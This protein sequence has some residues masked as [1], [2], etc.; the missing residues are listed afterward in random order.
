MSALPSTFHN[1]SGTCAMT[2]PAL[3]GRKPVLALLIRLFWA[4]VLV[5]PGFGASA[6]VVFTNLYSFTG[7]NDGANP[8]AGPV[9]GR[10][11]NLYG[12]TSSGGTN[13]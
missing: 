12:T 4:S 8:Y 5:L 9:Q 10:D 7:I 3:P 13:N 11:G 2:R 6:G 1:R